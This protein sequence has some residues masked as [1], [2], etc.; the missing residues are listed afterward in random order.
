M[1]ADKYLLNLYHFSSMKRLKVN[2]LAMAAVL[3]AAGTMAFSAPAAL[4]S[5][6]YLVEGDAIGSP[7]AGPSGD[8]KTTN[9][10]ELCMV[11]LQLNANE[12]IPETVSEAE[13]N[14]Q[15][16]RKAHRQF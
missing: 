4:D 1:T 6:W 14:G 16:I 13:A 9:T 7:A 12:P 8:C 5:G 11:Q 3:V 15:V 10:I 2:I